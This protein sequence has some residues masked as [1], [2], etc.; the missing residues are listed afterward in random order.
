MT[1]YGETIMKLMTPVEL[2][3]SVFSELAFETVDRANN[4]LFYCVFN[5][6]R[7]ILIITY[8]KS[9]IHGNRQRAGTT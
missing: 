1:G 3:H 9:R 6:N 7:Y 2:A 8:L 5:Y 4:I